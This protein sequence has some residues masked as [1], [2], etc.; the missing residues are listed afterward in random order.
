[1]DYCY[2]QENAVWTSCWQETPQDTSPQTG[3]MNPVEYGI[4]EWELEHAGLEEINK[5]IATSGCCWAEEQMLLQWRRTLKSRSY[6][7]KCREK[8]RSNLV[9]LAREKSALQRE[10][11]ELRREIAMYQQ[12]MQERNY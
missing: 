6:T 1:M 10:A 5:K 11:D 9:L 3:E 8:N 2:T 4:T 7:K 12:L